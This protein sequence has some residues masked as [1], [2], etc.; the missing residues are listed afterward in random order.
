MSHVGVCDRKNMEPRTL[1][2]GCSH[3]DNQK[4][5]FDPTGECEQCKGDLI[6]D[7]SITSDNYNRCAIR[8]A[9]FKEAM[10]RRNNAYV[11]HSIVRCTVPHIPLS[12]MK[13]FM[14]EVGTKGRLLE[15]TKPWDKEG[16]RVL[17]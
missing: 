8:S 9:I 4:A 1:C 12:F 10:R 3:A 7:Q 11:A 2:M 14:K 17:A 13:R 15:T 5:P 16:P 6:V